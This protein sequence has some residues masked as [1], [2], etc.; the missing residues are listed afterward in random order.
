M[1]SLMPWNDW[2]FLFYNLALIFLQKFSNNLVWAIA[3]F[4]QA[5]GAILWIPLFEISLHNFGLSNKMATFLIA[6]NFQS[7]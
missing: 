3:E 7:Q 6:L 5:V 1:D 2:G 4:S